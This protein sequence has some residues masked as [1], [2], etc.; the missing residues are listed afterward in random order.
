MFDAVISNGVFHLIHPVNSVFK[1][2]ERIIRPRGIFIF[3]YEP[4]IKLT[5]FNK[6]EPGIW[7]TKTT[8]GIITYKHE[9]KYIFQELAYSHF[10]ILEESRFLAFK[11]KQNDKEYYFTAVMVKQMGNHYY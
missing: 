7:K 3:T 2:I 9:D 8:S 5:V 11:N 1:E 6:I 10:E 4:A